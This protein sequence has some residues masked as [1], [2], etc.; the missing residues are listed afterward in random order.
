LSESL[1]EDHCPPLIGPS[2][3]AALATV[4]GVLLEVSVIVSFVQACEQSKDW[5]DTM[6]RILSRRKISPPLYQAAGRDGAFWS[7][8]G[9]VPRATWRLHHDYQRGALAGLPS[10]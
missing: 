8:P 1:V 2:Y 3:G 9:L 5:F 6:L 7:L 4:I 10:H